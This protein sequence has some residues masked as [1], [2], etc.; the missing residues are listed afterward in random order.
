MADDP[1]PKLTPQERQRWNSFIDYVAAQK[2]AGHPS[3]DQRNQSV[4]M[5][6]LSGFNK[7]YPQQALPA[8]I[9]PTVQ[10]ELNDY[11]TA[12]LERIKSGKASFDGKPE[13]FMPNLSATDGWPGTKT[14][15]SKFPAWIDT[16]TTPTG[17]TTVN[18]GPSYGDYDKG[19]AGMSYK[20]G[21]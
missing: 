12:M 1:K 2:M 5:S 21:K 19:L 16:K 13:E 14:L 17:T 8:D 10:A 20:G 4:G 9:V 18:N 7:A 3:L 11:R 6:L 15:S